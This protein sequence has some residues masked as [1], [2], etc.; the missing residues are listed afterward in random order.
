MFGRKGFHHR[1][2]EAQRT[3][4]ELKMRHKNKKLEFKT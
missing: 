1:E 4:K 2:T 3:A